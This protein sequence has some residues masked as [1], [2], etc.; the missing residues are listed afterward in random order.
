VAV[1]GGSYGT[2]TK[3]VTVQQG[4]KIAVQNTNNLGLQ[5]WNLKLHNPQDN[6]FNF[7]DFFEF[8][9]SHFFLFVFFSWNNNN[10]YEG[11]DT[12]ETNEARQNNNDGDKQPDERSTQSDNTTKR[13]IGFFVAF[14]VD[15]RT[16]TNQ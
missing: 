9:L 13:A 7:S 15:F 8:F 1:Q 11:A 16:W 12:T 5:I 4:V 10:I 2:V 6:P 3:C 14:S